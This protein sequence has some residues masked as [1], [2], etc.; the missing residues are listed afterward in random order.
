MHGQSQQLH[1]QASLLAAP[2]AAAFVGRDE[3][4]QECWARLIS[5]PGQLSAELAAQAPFSELGVWRYT[6]RS[7]QRIILRAPPRLQRYLRNRKYTTGSGRTRTPC[8]RRTFQVFPGSGRRSLS[9]HPAQLSAYARLGGGSW[10]PQGGKTFK[11]LKKKIWGALGGPSGTPLGRSSW[12]P[13]CAYAGHFCH[14]FL[15]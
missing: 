6:F 12:D 13:S 14:N 10:T 15:N 3:E 5:H 1:R 2:A 4:R 9:T 7:K 11:N 8:K